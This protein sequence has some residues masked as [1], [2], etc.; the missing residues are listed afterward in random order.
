[1]TP[2]P[3]GT[4]DLTVLINGH[5]E[6]PLIAPA[7]R[8][9]HAAIHPARARGVCCELLLVLDRGDDDTRAIAHGLLGADERL[10]SVDVGDPSRAR[11]IGV[12]NARGTAIALLDGDDMFGR[13]WLADAFE[14]L[15]RHRSADVC[16]HPATTVIFGE[17][18]VIWRH[19]GADHPD[20]RPKNTMFENYF[21]CLSLAPTCLFRR[22]PFRPCALSSGFGHEDWAWM[23]E[24]MHH[25]VRHLVVPG[26]LHAVR[27][28]RS[29]RLV[30]ARAL[31]L[32]PVPT[33]LFSGRDMLVASSAG[34]GPPRD[35]TP[36]CGEQA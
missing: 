8:S 35:E 28:K 6:G 18:R 12:E 11:N 1:M 17:E 30:E 14:A 31:D 20:F 16:L 21:T 27:R 36:N 32:L 23:R 24:T 33:P 5:R 29:S 22:V 34:G 26:T 7:I 9:A 2:N 13:S 3:T 19:I 10:L 25:G 4:I 15:R